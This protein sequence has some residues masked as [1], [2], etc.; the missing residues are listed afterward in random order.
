M[1][2]WEISRP[3]GVCS[4][5]GERI[6]PGQ[7][8]YGAL[9]EG[10]E[11][12]ERRDYSQGYWQENKPEV[13]CYWKSVLPTGEE[14][15][16]VFIDDD[17]LFAFFDRLADE[18]EQEKVDFRFVLTLVLMRK[19]LLKYQSSKVHQGGEMWTLKDMRTKDMTEVFN[20]GLSEER[21]DQ[22]KDQ[23]GQIMQGDI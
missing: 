1:A 15:K 12:L 10:A 21:M 7:E 4:G 5:C 11:G 9:V 3:L 18:D 19:R 2:E 13:Y 6:E 8:Y 17:M 20:P 22:L 14:K 23:M 16:K